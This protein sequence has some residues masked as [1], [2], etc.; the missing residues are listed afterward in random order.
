MGSRTFRAPSNQTDSIMMV[1]KKSE[2][3]GWLVCM[4]EEEPGAEEGE[5]EISVNGGKEETSRQ[6]EPHLQDAGSGNRRV[7]STSQRVSPCKPQGL[8]ILPK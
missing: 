4:S 3:D 5:A 2:S 1:K 8:S 7:Q 6:K